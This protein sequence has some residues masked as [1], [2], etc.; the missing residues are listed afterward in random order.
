MK[1]GVQPGVDQQQMSRQTRGEKHRVCPVVS[2]DL[3]M[4]SNSCESRLWLLKESKLRFN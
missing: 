3:I 4:K 1:A 2:F